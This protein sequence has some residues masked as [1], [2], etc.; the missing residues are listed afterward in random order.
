MPDPCEGQAGA[1]TLAE[2][3]RASEDSLRDSRS[4]QI[5]K[6]CSSLNRDRLLLELA[7]DS[8]QIAR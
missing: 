3:G 7:E 2:V 1:S 5:H 6:P 4:V 8:G